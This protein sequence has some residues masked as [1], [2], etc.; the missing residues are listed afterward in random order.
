[1]MQ[2]ANIRRMTSLLIL[3]LLLL[4][5]PA[6]AV[7][8]LVLTGHFKGTAT[9]LSALLFLAGVAAHWLL[10]G[11]ALERIV[12]GGLLPMAAAAAM[13]AVQ[14]TAW[15]SDIH[16]YFYV[17]MAVVAGYCDRWAL[18]AGA[19]VLEI[20][21]LATAFLAPDYLFPG[22]V[23]V[24]RVLLH[25]WLILF[26][27]GLLLALATTMSRAFHS[28]EAALAEAHEAREAIEKATAEREALAVQAR[29]ERIT[30]L[31]QVA[32]QLEQDV[33][34]LAVE[35]SAAARQA[36]E[37]AEALR[38]FAQKGIE[39]ADG[40]S[41]SSQGAS[42][43]VDTLAEGTEQLA[44]AISEIGEQLERSTAVSHR[45]T[46]KARDSQRIVASLSETTR[47]IDS[48]LG[49]ITDLASQTQLLALNATIEASR[50]GEAGKGFNVVANEVKNLAAQSA[51]SAQDVGDKIAAIRQSTDEAVAA[52][53]EIAQII[54][55]LDQVNAAIASAMTEQD[56]ATREM[57]SHASNAAA[58]T[59]VSA[60]LGDDVVR[61]GTSTGQA[62]DRM[63]GLSETLRQRTDRLT[64]AV[65][66]FVSQ[67]RRSA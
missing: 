42:E 29:E 14:G 28:A 32:D 63:T 43:S 18:I 4:Q 13:V 30:A 2:L 62:A 46:E 15:H 5:V 21:H 44:A 64:K 37:D 49:A 61:V 8:E 54:T 65:G 24:L 35:V 41:K 1:M 48:V 40:V 50:A 31:N 22:N 7:G 23:D 20:H 19:V 9:L 51:R 25:C 47:S 3:G 11:Q 33:G 27:T 59:R 56:A 58:A 6:I 66:A 26:Q 16:I 57:A 10:R 52:I 12:L 67:V 53:E 36:S 38:G 34:Q 45:A 55:D 39:I 60:Q 17:L